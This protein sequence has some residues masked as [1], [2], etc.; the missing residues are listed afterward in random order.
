MADLYLDPSDWDIVIS[1]GDV[2]FVDDPGLVARQAVVM[3]LKAFRG[4]WFK[5]IEYGTPWIKNENNSVSILGK[6]SKIIADSYVKGAILSN[7]EIRSILSYSSSIEPVSGRMT[8]NATLEIDDGS[9]Q[10]NEEIEI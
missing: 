7:P 10:I 9:I 1:D 6:T 2:V 4:E 5:N 3:T 8:V